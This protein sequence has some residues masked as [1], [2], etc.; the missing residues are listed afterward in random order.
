VLT[1]PIYK[2]DLLKSELYTAGQIAHLL[3]EKIEKF[4]TFYSNIILDLR[5]P[6]SNNGKSVGQVVESKKV[7]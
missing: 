7:N 1:T 2:D 5:Q 4:S 6:Q 3:K